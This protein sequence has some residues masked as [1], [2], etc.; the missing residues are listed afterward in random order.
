MLANI[1]K[2]FSTLSLNIT[3]NNFCFSFISGDSFEKNLNRLKNDEVCVDFELSS[4]LS[5]T[6]II[7]S[8][9]SFC[10]VLNYLI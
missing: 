5:I 10:K 1:L 4:L 6:S 9:S 8:A 2:E 7:A 3:Y